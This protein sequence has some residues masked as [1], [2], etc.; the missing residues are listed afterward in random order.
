MA[1]VLTQP[2][3]EI[4]CCNRLPLV[5][6][7]TLTYNLSQQVCAVRLLE[8]KNADAFMLDSVPSC[9]TRT[10]GSPSFDALSCHYG[11]LLSLCV[12]QGMYKMINRELP[13]LF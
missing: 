5:L 10:A 9:Y 11:L 12:T 4:L 2:T 1:K 6:R 7:P 3:A 13:N 8:P